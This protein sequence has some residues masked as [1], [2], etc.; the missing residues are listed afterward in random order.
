M[1]LLY[2]LS[3]YTLI[4]YASLVGS[5]L[6]ISQFKDKENKVIEEG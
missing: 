1:D 4:A 2:M 3:L 5:I 6:V